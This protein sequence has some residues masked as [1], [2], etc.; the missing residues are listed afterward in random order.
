M[1]P[2]NSITKRNSFY[3][4]ASAGPQSPSML[5]NQSPVTNFVGNSTILSL[6]QFNIRNQL[7]H[8]RSNC[9]IVNNNIPLETTD[10]VSLSSSI[11]SSLSP[12][13]ITLVNRHNRLHLSTPPSN[14][15]FF[16][17]SNSKNS[18][19]PVSSPKL[20]QTPSLITKGKKKLFELNLINK[21]LVNSKKTIKNEKKDSRRWS[22]AS[23]HSSGFN[24]I[25]STSISLLPDSFK[26]KSKDSLPLH[27][28]SYN[29]LQD[30]LD[31]RISKNQKSFS[32]HT[33]KLPNRSSANNL[34]INSYGIRI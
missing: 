33:D 23:V 17:N 10:N 9:C 16:F 34:K 12:S 31:C 11:C 8:Y 24:L 5:P 25:N 21:K 27:S 18:H 4:S 28:S 2:T 7:K 14:V 6:N 13:P 22:L 32:D 1:Y 26:E 3:T 20:V 15:Q 19:Q 29:N 30:N